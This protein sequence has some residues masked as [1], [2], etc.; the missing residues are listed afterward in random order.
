VVTAVIDALDSAGLGT[1]AQSLQMPC[2]AEQ[3]W[4]VLHGGRD[5]AT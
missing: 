5:A 3:V 4:R 1:Q 2:T